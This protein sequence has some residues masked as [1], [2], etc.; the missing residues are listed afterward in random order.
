M[1]ARRSSSVA[2][3]RPFSNSL[4]SRPSSTIPE[5]SSARPASRTH[6]R[7]SGFRSE[8]RVSLLDLE[9]FPGMK[10]LGTFIPIRLVDLVGRKKLLMISILAVALT[11]VCMGG[12][13]LLINR[14]SK[15]KKA[16][17]NRRTQRSRLRSQCRMLSS[18]NSVGHSGYFS[19]RTNFWSNCD[20]C[21]TNDHCGFCHP[22]D[23]PSGYCLP[24][25]KATDLPS[26]T[27][28][29]TNGTTEDFEWTKNYCKTNFT[30][31]PIILMVVFVLSF[32][33]GNLFRCCIYFSLQVS[34]RCPGCWTRNS[35][36]YGL[37]AHAC[38]CRQRLTG[39]S[40]SL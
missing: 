16:K 35:T 29:C 11:L 22:K 1:S 9:S 33:S 37:G 36:H 28:L 21:V 38:P 25:D 13:F 31:I 32:A 40:I 2:D 7:S 6:I 12:A 14:V 23:S 39:L 15:K 5:W 3:F 20:F 26:T 24:L 30:V 19:G 27:G 4:G 8:F 10:V 34:R 18:A 17:G